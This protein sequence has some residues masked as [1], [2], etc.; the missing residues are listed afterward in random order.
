MFF[1]LYHSIILKDGHKKTKKKT[2]KN[3]FT[4]SNLGILRDKWSRL[5]QCFSLGFQNRANDCLY[6]CPILFI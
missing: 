5:K 3:V 2:E 1:N 6:I 4:F